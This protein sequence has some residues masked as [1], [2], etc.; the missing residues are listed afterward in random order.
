MSEE[1][2]GEVRAI[3]LEDGIQRDPFCGLEGCECPDH[4]FIYPAGVYLTIRLD[5]DSPAV[6]GIHLSRVKLTWPDAQPTDQ[7]HTN[8]IQEKS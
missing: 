3:A 8:R 4:E 5:A 1:M 2:L 6:R 7:D